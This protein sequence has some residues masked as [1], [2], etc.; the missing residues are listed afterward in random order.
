MTKDSSLTRILR[1]VL[2]TAAFQRLWGDGLQTA[3]DDPV[4]L[5][6]L[7]L[8]T[9]GE[10]SG[11]A[12]ADR[13]LSLIEATDADGFAQFCQALRDGFEVDAEKVIA[14]AVA[15]R[16]GS[17]VALEALQR[18]AEPP[19]Q[20]LFRRLNAAP[21]GTAR[22]VR[23]RER[24]LTAQRADTS[25]APLD[26]DLRHLL[27]SWFNRGFLVPTRIDWHTPA[28]LL[29]KIIAHEAVHA[30]DT[31]DDLR[32]RLAPPDRRCFA[33]FHPAMP[34]E[35]LIFVEVALTRGLATSIQDVLDSARPV[36]APDEADTAI[37][38]S[39]SNCQAGLAGI[40]FGAFLIKQVAADLRAEVPGLKVFATLS[41]VP[42][43]AAWTAAQGLEAD[44]LRADPDLLQDAASTYLL[45]AKDAGGRPLDP[46]ARFHL[47]NGAELHRINPDGNLSPK[48]LAQSHGVMVNY[49]YD[50]DQV[51]AR[52]EAHAAS[53]EIAANR[54]VR[55]RLSRKV[56]PR[57]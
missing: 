17:A 5:G 52:H 41:P 13:M 21:H 45:T 38:Y 35:P 7:L 3:Q 8:S 18:A 16:S 9:R 40:S 14:A 55:A 20:E 6:R 42:G 32:R 48:G 43:F 15:A 10:V 28:A 33:F 54:A 47:G 1:N 51:E 57:P 29:E 37:F 12:I 56:P 25:L 23:F 4:A 27:R 30:I 39:I 53:G 34:D 36:I 50:L 24:L 26:A 22:L 19:R 31:W 11:Q 49:L 2:G 46:V 44:A